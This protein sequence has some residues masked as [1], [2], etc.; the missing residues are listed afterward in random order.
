MSSPFPTS[1]SADGRARRWVA[2]A[3]L[4]A[5]APVFAGCYGNF[6]L[7]SAVYEFNTDLADS[8]LARS[9][10]MWL[11]L[12]VPV[13]EVALLGD[14]LVIHLIEFWGGESVDVTATTLDDGTVVTMVPSADGRELVLTV[15][16][17]GATLSRTTCAKVSRT[18]FEV[19]NARGELTG[20]VVRAPNGDLRLSDAAGA[21][22][23]TLAAR[24]V[25][26]LCG[27]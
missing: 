1:R 15:S 12:V 25:A 3:L 9:A 7:T 26:I 19:R 6:P 20:R 21:T 18:E 22:V 10:T 24:D 17:H 14:M 4:V 13:Y 5:M 23:R 2:L 27:G 8:D 11:L 16:R